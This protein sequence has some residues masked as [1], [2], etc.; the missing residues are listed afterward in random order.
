VIVIIT[1]RRSFLCKNSGLKQIVLFRFNL[2]VI[3]R[4]ELVEMSR[5]NGIIE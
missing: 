5:Q 3:K 1:I 2:N 4:T